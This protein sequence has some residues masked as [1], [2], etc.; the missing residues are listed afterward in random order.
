M[1]RL[2][3]RRDIFLGVYCHSFLSCDFQTHTHT[4]VGV[5]Q[6][7]ICPSPDV[8][9]LVKRILLDYMY[10]I[11]V[12]RCSHFIMR[13]LMFSKNIGL[14]C[15]L[16]VRITSVTWDI[17]CVHLGS[18]VL[19]NAHEYWYVFLILDVWR[20]QVSCLKICATSKNA[21][22]SAAANCTL[23]TECFLLGVV[24]VACPSITRTAGS[25]YIQLVN[26][27]SFFTFAGPISFSLWSHLRLTF[28]LSLSVH[29][30]FTFVCF[31]C[32]IFIVLSPLHMPS[33]L[34]S[35]G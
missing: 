32:L 30:C 34:I 19:W 33:P 3:S 22:C 8:F 25:F 26:Y 4:L 10:I 11:C 14:K 23:P 7:L 5:S 29:F 12:L 24:L 15:T 28:I 27:F 17:G 6:H 1:C 20:S 31:S 18:F 9:R 16:T 2:S 13:P 35:L 21:C